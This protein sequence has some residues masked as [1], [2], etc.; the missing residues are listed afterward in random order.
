MLA[1]HWLIDAARPT[2]STAF[3]TQSRARRGHPDPRAVDARWFGLPRPLQSSRRSAKGGGGGSGRA[4]YGARVGEV[5]QG[6]V[7]WSASPAL[8]CPAFS[9][10]RRVGWSR[11]GSRGVRKVLGKARRVSRRGGAKEANE[12]LNR[13]RRA[14]RPHLPHLKR[15]DRA[16]TDAELGWGKEVNVTRTSPASPSSERPD[17]ERSAR[18]AARVLDTERYSERLPLVERHLV[19][20][21]RMSPREVPS[22]RRTQNDRRKERPLDCAAPRSYDADARLRAVASSIPL[23]SP[24]MTPRVPS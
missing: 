15:G 19:V 9:P 11:W 5:T 21:R 1:G 24:S 10:S 7:I 6:G 17:G 8:K 3:R 18:D 13:D 22:E 12:A 4:R 20:P 16:E 23:L 14:T 2:R